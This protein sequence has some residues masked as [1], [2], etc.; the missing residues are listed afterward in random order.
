LTSDLY[1]EGGVRAV[2]IP[3]PLNTVDADTGEIVA[4]TFEFARFAIPRRVLT[5]G[6][7]EYVAKVMKRVKDNAQKSKGYRLT[8]WP[9]MLGHFFARF[10][11]VQ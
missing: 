11:P 9:K 8:Y 1:L 7:I 4:R 3:F 5:K 10:E 6:H 2:A